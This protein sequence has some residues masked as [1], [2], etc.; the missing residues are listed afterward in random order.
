MDN[1]NMAEFFQPEAPFF[2]N[3]RNGKCNFDVQEYVRDTEWSKLSI[4]KSDMK[5][6]RAIKFSVLNQK[7]FQFKTTV[8]RKVENTGIQARD[9]YRYELVVDIVPTKFFPKAYPAD[10][11]TQ[12]VMGIISETTP[13]VL[14]ASGKKI[15]DPSKRDRYKLTPRE[16]EDLGNKLMEG[17][18]KPAAKLID[19]SKIQ[20]VDRN[21][22]G[23]DIPTMEEAQRELPFT[24]KDLVDLMKSFMES[25]KFNYGDY[26]NHSQNIDLTQIRPQSNRFVAPPTPV[27]DF[28]ASPT[29]VEDVASAPQDYTPSD[30]Q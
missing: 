9:Y 13:K 19:W 10:L 2:I 23:K 26:K 3:E 8:L 15:T 30:L 5:T 1:S 20:I 14:D 11:Y 24:K 27:E 25:Y 22:T 21:D 16:L 6:G 18:F 4:L 7:G 28:V 29:P 12:P 17:L